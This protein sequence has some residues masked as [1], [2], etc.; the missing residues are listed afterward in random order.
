MANI[1]KSTYLRE[2]AVSKPNAGDISRVVTFRIA[3]G[4]DTALNVIRLIRLPKNAKLLPL[5]WYIETED[6][7]T[8]A[9]PTLDMDLVVTDGTTTHTIIN[10]GTLFQSAGKAFD[11]TSTSGQQSGWVNFVTT[12]SNF[13][14]G[15]LVNTA[16]ATLATTAD[17]IVSC[18]YTMDLESGGV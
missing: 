7:D 14:V 5:G 4:E 17:I 13:A 10:A 16:A 9:T 15:L 6:A 8:G 2:P 18:K 3:A 12:N 11:Q 1:D